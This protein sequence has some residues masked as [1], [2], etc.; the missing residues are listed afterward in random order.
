MKILVTGGAGYIGSHT[1]LHLLK[2]GHDV[3]II[4]NFSNSSPT[5]IDRIKKLAHITPTLVE[6]DILDLPFLNNLFSDHEFDAVIHFA[7]VK[8][9][10]ESV[11][12]P[13]LYYQTNVTGSLNLLSAMKSYNV[14]RFI[15]SSSATVYGSPT[16]LPISETAVKAPTNPY[17]NSKY[18][19]EQALEDL[20]KSD[21]DWRIVSLRYFNP[22]GADESGLIGEHPRG[23]PNNLMPFISQVACGT[24]DK[25]LVFGND[26][27][28]HDGTGVRDYIH[29]SDLAEGHVAAL[30]FISNSNNGIF[31]PANLGAGKGYSVLDLIEAFEKVSNKKILYSVAER[32]PGDIATSFADPRKAN[33]L[34]EWYAKKG[35]LEMCA[36]TW[37][38]QSKNPNGYDNN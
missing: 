38:W 34:F 3:V 30:N 7:G 14:K 19:V 12:D 25:L 2:T 22:V 37:R 15:F 36:D 17:G 4:D 6:G 9:V 29:V 20:F 11:A 33:N 1:T 10:G 23:V 21:K 31:C 35:I 26:Y 24:R 13:L 28:T 27:P 16:S 8:A 32:R 18:I 5:V